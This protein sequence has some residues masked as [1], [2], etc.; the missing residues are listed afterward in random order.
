VTGA[1][2]LGIRAM[3]GTQ[4]MRVRMQ[5]I[6]AVDFSRACHG[7]R[8]APAGAAF[9]GQQVIPTVAFVEMRRLRKADRRALENIFVFSFA[10]ESVSWD[11]NHQNCC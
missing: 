7:D 3:T 2:Q 11:G 4:D 8:V 10:I 5:F 1:L 9:R 6:R